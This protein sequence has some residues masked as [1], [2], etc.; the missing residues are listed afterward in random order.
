MMFSQAVDHRVE[1]TKWWVAE[2]KSVKFPATGTIFDYYIDA[3]TKQFTPWTE[4]LPKFEL[5]PDVPLQVSYLHGVLNS[6][7]KT[8]I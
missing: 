3:E 1:F 5:D 4:R 6:A 8:F 7:T 2:F